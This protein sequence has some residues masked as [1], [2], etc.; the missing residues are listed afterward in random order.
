MEKLKTTL[1]TNVLAKIK[2]NLTNT[3][4]TILLYSLPGCGKTYIA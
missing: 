3:A 2:F 4:N 1:R